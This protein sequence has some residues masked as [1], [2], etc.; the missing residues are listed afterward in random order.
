VLQR[1]PP[2][3]A[4]RAAVSVKPMRRVSFSLAVMV[5]VGL[6]AVP[7]KDVR[8]ATLVIDNADPAGQGLNDPTAFS[9]VGGNNATTLGAARLAVFAQAA[10]IWG[11]QLS[12]VVPIHV[13][14]QIVPLSCTATSAVL[15]STGA[16]SVHRDFP[17]APLPATWYPQALANALAGTDLAPTTPDIETQF[18]SALGSSG[19]LTGSPFYLGLDGQPGSGEVDMLT[20]ALHEFAH[21]LG[22]QS[23]ADFSTGQELS[24]LDDAFLANAEE[25]GASVPELSAMTDQQRAA[26]ALSDPDLYWSGPSVQAAA[27]TLSAGLIAGHVRLYAPAT[28]AAGSSVSHYSTAL[29]PNQLMEP[30]YS[31]PTRDLT[32]T[33][34]LL[35]DIGWPLAVAPKNVPALPAGPRILL[36]LALAA[37][38]LLIRTRGTPDT[39]GRV[40]H[41]A[42]GSVGDIGRSPRSSAVAA[43]PRRR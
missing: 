13:S 34:D 16:A 23:Y 39:V 22:F 21:G 17:S 38:A 33:V 30:F 35:R 40:A 20:I 42:T 12:S 26:A 29:T 1:D 24:G 43:P 37:G 41:G 2:L 10:A 7:S 14:T 3:A 19:C 27:S 18:N 36:V 31:G 4:T 6:F 28:L 9:P 5:T 15:A 32:L 25:L 8:A 11:T